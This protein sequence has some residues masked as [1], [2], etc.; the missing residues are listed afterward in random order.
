MSKSTIIYEEGSGTI[1]Q[2]PENYM[3]AHNHKGHWITDPDPA[4]DWKIVK[5]LFRIIFFSHELR[6][7]IN[8]A[9]IIERFN[10][11]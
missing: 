4:A 2:M 9:Y 11:V 5:K 1:R 7:T 6:W 10:H 8:G 3:L